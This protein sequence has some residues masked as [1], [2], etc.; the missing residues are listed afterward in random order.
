NGSSD[1]TNQILDELTKANPRLHAL[2]ETEPNYGRALKHAILEARGEYVICEE[3]DLLNDDFHQKAMK[4]LIAKEADMVVGSKAHP[5]AHDDRG[6]VRVQG[7][8]VLNWMLRFSLGYEGTD[9]HG[10]KA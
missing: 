5:D 6:F 8:V 2:H 10:L 1:D 4:I 7:T 9:T 3:I